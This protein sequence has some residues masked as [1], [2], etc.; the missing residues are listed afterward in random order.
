MKNL[1]KIALLVMWQIAMLNAQSE[2]TLVMSIELKNNTEIQCILPGEVEWEEWDKPYVRMVVEIKSNTSDDI[3][4]KLMIAGRYKAVTYAE[5]GMEH[6]TMPKVA[7]QIILQGVT[8]LVPKGTRVHST[9]P[10]YIVE[11]K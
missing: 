8:L 2:K 7:K 11:R 10:D 6:L 5:F 3:L 4:E 9:L 1:I